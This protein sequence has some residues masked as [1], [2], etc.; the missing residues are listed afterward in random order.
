MY[1]FFA[2]SLTRSKMEHSVASPTLMA[3]IFACFPSLTTFFS[4][5][6]FDGHKWHT[7][8]G[9]THRVLVETGLKSYVPIFCFEFD[10]IKN[11]ISVAS[12]SLAAG[13]FARS[14]DLWKS[15][16][17]TFTDDVS[18]KNQFVFLIHMSFY[19]ALMC[20]W[21]IFRYISLNSHAQNH[22]RA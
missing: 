3:G 17:H 1:P 14:Y 4:S 8:R 19:M 11:G 20:Y 13:I 21:P 18:L 6:R 5:Y 7:T 9:S 22:H 12:P 15:C 10:A 16:F 2:S